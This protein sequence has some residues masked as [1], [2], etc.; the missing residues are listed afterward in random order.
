MSV[1]TLFVTT[2]TGDN[3]PTIA[4]SA[5]L[6]LNVKKIQQLAS[7]TGGLSIKFQI[8]CRPPLEVPGSPLKKLQVPKRRHFIIYVAN[9]PKVLT[10]A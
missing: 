1:E 3:R 9:H 4:L 10:A 7:L 8:P 2:Q 6:F 5:C